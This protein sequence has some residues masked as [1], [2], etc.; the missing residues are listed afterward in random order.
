MDYCAGWRRCPCTG[1]FRL[2]KSLFL[3]ETYVG[4]IAAQHAASAIGV[5]EVPAGLRKSETQ[6]VVVYP[7]RATTPSWLNYCQPSS[8]HANLRLARLSARPPA[9]RTRGACT[10]CRKRRPS[11][12]LVEASCCFTTWLPGYVTAVNNWTINRHKMPQAHSRADAN[13][14]SMSESATGINGRTQEVECR[15]K[16]AINPAVRIRLRLQQF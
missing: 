12:A 2:M 3:T 4:T 1:L 16:Q 7:C 10:S 9:E 5:I 14:R 15:I 6:E 11:L 13:S 8:A